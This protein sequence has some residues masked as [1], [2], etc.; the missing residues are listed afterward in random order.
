[1]FTKQ[2]GPAAMNNRISNVMRLAEEY[3]AGQHC[4]FATSCGSDKHVG[5]TELHRRRADSGHHP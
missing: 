5:Y 1:M 2:V 3:W 4:E